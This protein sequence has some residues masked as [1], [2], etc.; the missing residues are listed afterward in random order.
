MGRGNT[1]YGRPRH[2]GRRSLTILTV[3]LSVPP[4]APARTPTP[5]RSALFRRVACCFRRDTLQPLCFSFGRAH[6]YASCPSRRDDA[7]R[8]CFLAAMTGS[9]GAT[10]E[11]RRVG[12]ARQ[13]PAG[14]FGIATFKALLNRAA[15]GERGEPLDAGRSAGAGGAEIIQRT[16]HYNILLSEFDYVENYEAVDLFRETYLAVSRTVPSRSTTSSPTPFRSTRASS[17]AL[18]STTP[19]QLAGQPTYSVSGSSRPVRDDRSIATLACP[20]RG[21]PHPKLG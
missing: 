6:A 8:R 14:G 5:T 1:Q 20:G 12:P 13:H 18:T 4:A 3:E 10:T 16:A 17:R 21:S 11:P 2:L 19:A 15:E 7:V 9:A